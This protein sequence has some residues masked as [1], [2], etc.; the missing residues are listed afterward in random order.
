MASTVS[1]CRDEEDLADRA[2]GH[3]VEAARAAVDDHGRFTLCLSGGDT[4]RPTYSRLASA[5]AGELPWDATHI[6]W[7]D[8]RCIPLDQEDNH[9]TMASE[10]MLS[11][12]PIPP[13]QIHR[14]R[15]EAEDPGEAAAE[16]E[17]GLREFFAPPPDGFP[18]FDLVLLGMGD[19]GHVASLYPGSAGLPEAERWVVD[20][21][22]LKHGRRLRRLSLTMPVLTAAAEV[23]VLVSGDHKAGALAGVLSGTADVPARTL[24]ERAAHVRWMVTQDA[25]A[26]LD[27]WIEAR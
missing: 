15:G 18:S 1:I 2:S 6:F 22:V 3:I 17:A 20:H 24:A 25:A 23:M 4:P 14:I 19:D 10:L 16:Y 26:G 21:Y 12:V 8:E 27:E 9:F 13:E 11:R 7:G 5:R